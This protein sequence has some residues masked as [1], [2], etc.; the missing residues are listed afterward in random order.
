[1]QSRLLRHVVLLLPLVFAIAPAFAQPTLSEGEQ[2]QARIDAA[3]RAHA[4]DERY[5][6]LSPKDRLGL[7]EFVAGNMLFALLHEMGHAVVS[8]T[9]LPV[10]GKEEDAA[11]AFAATR[12]ISVAS[13][14]S[15]RVLA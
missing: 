7:A 4:G 9:G 8:D 10:L 5:K 13:G 3:A 6:G 12:L 11:D 15:D 14:F 2:L 1:M